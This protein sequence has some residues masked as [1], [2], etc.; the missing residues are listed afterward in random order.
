VT[1]YVRRMVQSRAVDDLRGRH[2]RDG[3]ELVH[4][5]ELTRTTHAW[6][7]PEVITEERVL[8]DLLARKVAEL[9]PRCRCAYVMVRERCVPYKAEALGAGGDRAVARV[10]TLRRHGYHNRAI[11]TMQVIEE[12]ISLAKNLDAASIR[13]EELG[14]TDD[15]VAFY[16]ALASNDSAAQAMG[17]D[18][19]KVI[20]AELITQVKKSVSIDWT[21]RES[22]RARIKVIVKRI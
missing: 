7:S 8:G 17:N 2:R 3:R 5:R 12:S 13:G 10:C 9:P 1:R 18:K 22:A 15:E 19:L 4:G 20:A 11:S 21:L 14:L 16:D 6:M